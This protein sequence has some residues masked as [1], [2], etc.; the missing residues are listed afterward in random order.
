MKITSP[1]FLDG[2]LIPPTYTCDGDNVNP[3]LEISDV[4]EG[5]KSLAL[6]MDDP[7]APK[8]TF[9]HWLMWN[10]PPNTRNIPENDWLDGAEQGLNDAGELGYMGACPP[11]GVHHYRFKLYALN[12]VLNLTGEIRKEDLEREINNSLIEKTELVGLYKLQS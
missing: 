2:E 12:S 6:I 1:A 5:T 10:I 8:E 9:T 3:P 7:D 11:A 4:P